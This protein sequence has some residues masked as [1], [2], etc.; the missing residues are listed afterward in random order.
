[1][2]QPNSNELEYYYREENTHTQTRTRIDLL[3][4]WR[5]SDICPPGWAGVKRGRKT[6]AFQLICR[7]SSVAESPSRDAHRRWKKKDRIKG[8]TP[9]RTR[10]SPKLVN[11][12][13]V[14][15]D[16]CRVLLKRQ[17]AISIRTTLSSAIRTTL[18][19]FLILP[20]RVTYVYYYIISNF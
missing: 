8:N 4:W 11:V 5:R 7:R 3:K 20:E 16:R 2:L 10:T 13:G 12:I 15:F 18:F 14:A 6:S 17:S 9:G 19:L 1:M